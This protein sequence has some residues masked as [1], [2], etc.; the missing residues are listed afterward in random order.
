M[1]RTLRN[2]LIGAS[3]LA[4]AAC[5]TAAFNSEIGSNLDEG[6][7]G[8]PTMNNILVMSGQR[9]YHVNLANRFASEVP[10]TVNFAFNSTVLDA[11]ATAALA[12]QARTSAR[13]FELLRQAKA[14]REPQL[15]DRAA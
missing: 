11:E 9:D 4:L 8:N 13:E 3:L 10:S 6:G 7:F 12:R 5:D 2:L 15:L 14:E 1:Q